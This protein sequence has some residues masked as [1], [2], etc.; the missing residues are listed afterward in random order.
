MPQYLVKIHEHHHRIV[1]VDADTEEDAIH[2]AED[3]QG[4]LVSRA[5]DWD[6]D[7]DTWNVS[8]DSEEPDNWGREEA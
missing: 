2:K 8:L 5:K 3:G 4:E 7:R 6:D 1:R